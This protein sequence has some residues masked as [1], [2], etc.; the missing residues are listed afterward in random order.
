MNERDWVDL[1]VA[2][3]SVL[4]SLGILATIG[5]YFWQ[6]KDNKSKQRE[7]DRKLLYFVNIK[8]KE[9]LKK[10]N[11][12]LHLINNEGEFQQIEMQKNDLRYVKGLQRDNPLFYKINLRLNSNEFLDR[13]NIHASLGLFNFILDI[14]SLNEEFFNKTSQYIIYAHMYLPDVPNEFYHC[15]D[16]NELINFLHNTK[17]K[18]KE[19]LNR[20][21]D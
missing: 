18:I 4:S 3:S 9:F 1:V 21:S 5:V 13:N 11:N 12:V 7:I 19:N 10:I 16:K 14:D 8:A 15:I 17:D 6:K 20:L 2:G